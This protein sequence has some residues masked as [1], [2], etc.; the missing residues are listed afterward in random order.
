MWNFEQM[1]TCTAL[2][3]ARIKNILA[4]QGRLSRGGLCAFLLWALAFSPAAGLDIR[5]PVDQF[6]VSFR[7]DAWSE[8]RLVVVAFLGVDCPLGALYA[9]RLNELYDEF[10]GRGVCFVA[11]DANEHDSYPEMVAFAQRLKFSM[12]KDAGNAVADAFGATRSPEV[13][14]LNGNRD[15]I[16]RGRIDDQYAPGVHSRAAPLRRD[17]EEAILESLANRPV[18]VPVTTPVGCHL[19]RRTEATPVGEVTYTKH[20]ARIFDARCAE[21]HR[22]GAAAPFSL[23]T[24]DDARAWTGTI[25]EVL[26]QRRMPPWGVEGGHFANDRSLKDDERSLIFAWLDSGAPEGMPADR[27]P[28]PTFPSGWRI[29]PDRVFT[30]PTPFTVPADGVLEYQEFTLDPGFTEDT[31]IQDVE[32]RPGNRAVVHH[33]NVYL[34]PKGAKPDRLYVNSLGDYY[35]AMTVPGNAITSMPAGTAKVIPAG[36]TLVLSIHYA[37]NGT[38]QSDQTSIALTLADP[39]TVRRQVATRALL[40]EHLVIHPH[41]KRTA[42]QTWITEDDYTLFALYPHMHLRGRSMRFDARYPDGR[43]EVL[44]NVTRFDFAWQYRY[45]LST[46]IELPRGTVIICT[47]QYDNS[48]ENP[49]NPDPGA[50]VRSG[51]QTTD[52]MFQACFEICRTHEDRLQPKP[53]LMTIVAVALGCLWMVKRRIRSRT[54]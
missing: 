32:I 12:V 5:G 7:L 20:I 41:R 14:L 31:W 8:D 29:R 48:E 22:P 30:M 27:P 54:P 43:S 44:L 49:A 37:P 11:V 24:Y 40:D 36:W 51:P 10:A 16:Y 35:L 17:L 26:T 23:L 39:A 46:P 47:A 3:M 53:P 18:S 13:F 34:R 50:T 21:C 33:V 42:R 52:E 2:G 38:E 28:L 6:G 9:N 1:R 4:A 25:R 19:D 45:V 15:V